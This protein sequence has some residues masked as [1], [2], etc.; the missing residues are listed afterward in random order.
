MCVVCRHVE[1]PCSDLLLVL[2]DRLTLLCTQIPSCLNTCVNAFACPVYVL[3]YSLVP[4]RSWAS[5][6]EQK[7][8]RITKETE[9]LGRD[10]EALTACGERRALNRLNEKD[11]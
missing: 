1:P 2:A 9:S 6:D 10:G 7:R 3:I 5:R 11:H 4:S 8:T